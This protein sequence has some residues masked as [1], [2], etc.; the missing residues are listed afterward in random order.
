MALLLLFYFTL[1]ISSQSSRL[2]T[3]PLP[4]TNELGSGY[5]ALKMLSASEQRSKFRIFNLGEQSAD[6]FTVKVN[7]KDHIYTTPLLAQATNI[8]LRKEMNCESI[9]Y[10]IEQFYSRLV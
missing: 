8:H 4:G 6:L 1:F 9:S 10:T 5:Q 7:G 3:D 2:V